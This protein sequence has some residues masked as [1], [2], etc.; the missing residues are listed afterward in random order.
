MGIGDVS[1]FRSKADENNGFTW[2]IT[3]LTE[4]GD[5]PAIEFD[6]RSL[7]GTVAKGVVSEHRKGIS[8]PFNSLD[9]ANGLPLGSAIVTDLSNLAVTVS[10]LEQGVEY[11][12]RVAAVNAV[13]QGPY[14]F[15]SVP[16]AIPKPQRPGVPSSP[17]LATVDSKTL[18]TSFN[19]PLLDGG[20]DVTSYRVEYATK[21][22]VAEVQRVSARCNV[23]NEVQIVNTT[24]D[25]IPEVQMVYINTTYYGT[26]QNAT[27]KVKCDATGGTFKLVFNKDYSTDLILWDATAQDIE[28]ALE[29]ISIINDVTVTMNSPATTACSAGNMDGFNV[30]F[31]DVTNWGGNLPDLSSVTNNLLGA[32]NITVMTTLAGHA[33]IGGSFRLSFRGSMTETIPANATE[34]ELKTALEKLDTISA[35]P[36]YGVN[37]EKYFP[38]GGNDY[39]RLWKITF[40]GTELEGDVEALEVVSQYNLLTGSYVSI[41][42]FH[43]GSEIRTGYS[44]PYPSHASSAGNEVSGTFTLTFRDHTTE[45]IEFLAADSVMKARVEALPN[46]GTVAVTRSAPSVK[47]EYS[48]SITFL[49]MPGAFPVGSFPRSYGESALLTADFTSLAGT[50]SNVKVTQETTGSNTLT[51]I[52]ALEYRNTSSSGQVAAYIPVDASASELAASLNTLTNAGTVSV[53]REVLSDGYTWLVTF[54]GCEIRNGVDVCNHG[55]VELLLPKAG[56]NSTNSCPITTVTV[57]PGSGADA[58]VNGTNGLCGDIVMDLSGGEPYS[59]LITNLKAGT[60]YY[61]RVMAHNR[62]GYGYPALTL[63]EYETPSYLPPGAPPMVR[64]ES[65]SSTELTLVWDKPRENGGATV[66]GYELW[67]DDWSGGSERLVFDGTDDPNTRTFTVSTTGA[68]PV[69][70]GQSY[71]FRVRAMNYCIATDSSKACYGEFSEPAAYVVR[72]PRAPLPPPMPYRSS[73]SNIG[74]ATNVRSDATITIRWE[75]PIDNGG[76]PIAQYSVYVSKP[77]E[78]TFTQVSLANVASYVVSGTENLVMEYSYGP[79]NQVYDGS[80]YRFYVRAHNNAGFTS[81]SS[82]ILSTVASIHAGIDKNDVL[83]Y[84]LN[85]QPTAR[86]VDAGEITVSWPLPTTHSNGGTPITGFKVYMYPGVGLNTLVNPKQVFQEVQIVETTVDNKSPEEHEIEIEE[87]PSGNVLLLMNGKAQAVAINANA[88]TIEAAIE[89]LYPGFCDSPPCV[90]N[91]VT[92]A[93]AESGTSPGGVRWTVTYNGIDMPVDPM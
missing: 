83:Q 90:A 28:N 29:A 49:S 72:A 77:G 62:E 73:K 68:F 51:G 79:P 42:V 61:V 76:S 91:P 32:R 45:P 81:A 37:V 44:W 8:P 65:S 85:N 59:Y 6:G 60:P 22:F 47:K 35:T 50:N 14:S 55:D 57:T 54:D 23:T 17:T 19:A 69:T 20:E 63:P 9:Q 27:Q 78:T 70:S 34:N 7:E 40:I 11:Y 2:S 5:V 66:K 38:S 87:V 88:A 4:L 74:T 30:V 86:G 1:V 84:A 10:G 18:L 33:N 15:A 21:P 93:T 41:E 26:P 56:Y 12:F 36:G 13:G 16:Y 92:Y 58:C 80:I 53:T 67:M 52:F 25:S 89:A 31:N 3:F 71:R 43:D 82:P 39:D 75:V 48:W 46:V 64:M 24:T